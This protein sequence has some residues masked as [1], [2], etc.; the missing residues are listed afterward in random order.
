MLPLPRLEREPLQ[1]APIGRRHRVAGLFAGIGGIERGLC[2]AR[3]ETVLLCENDPAAKVVL[4]ARFPGVPLHDDVRTLRTLPRGTSLVAAGFPCQ[5]LSQAGTTNGIEGEQS[6]LIE[7]VMRLV[8]KHSTPWVL[9]ENVPFMLQ[10]ARGE[11]MHVITTAFEAMGYR[12][13]Y[14]VVDSRAFG[15]PQRRRRVYFL[16]SLVGDP[17]TVIFADE[18]GEIPESD[19]SWQS[20]ACGFYWTEGTRGLGW[21]FDAIPTLKG[22]SGLG[23][24][25]SP[26]II[27]PD[28][29]V[30]TP[31]LSDAERLQGFPKN[32]T[33]P[34]ERVAK[35]GIRWKLV[36][37]AVGV[38]AAT[39]IGRRLARP[40][41][42]IAYKT[43][44][45]TDHRHWPVAAWNLG[46]G[47]ERVP[48]SEWP[49]R[50]PY[51]SLEAFLRAPLKPLS[52]KATSGF[53]RRAEQAKLR[54]QAGFL[55]ALRT[56]IARLSSPSAAPTISAASATVAD[57]A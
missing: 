46:E 31:A 1:E 52:L 21:A 19:G 40:R 18:A 29:R 50:L 42:P 55:D 48:A 8:K 23:I 51:Q 22:G 56:H 33:R 20:V 38:D 9:L 43:T 35:S 57:A 49:V 47:R 36:G 34:A 28:G 15:R 10:L 45:L 27:M 11:A 41:A 13:A 30:V 7:E 32:W 2:R 6:G 14:R 17:R 44:P 39:W 12:W 16:A 3:H 25:S 24:P 53:V 4:G 5:D 37:N 26:A 54:F